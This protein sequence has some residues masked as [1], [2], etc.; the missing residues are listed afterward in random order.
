MAVASLVLGIVSLAF[1]WKAGCLAAGAAGLILGV[2]SRVRKGPGGLVLVGIILSSIG[3][4]Q[5]IVALGS[6]L[7]LH[8]WHRTPPAGIAV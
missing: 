4:A 1:P 7:F 2:V 3:L 6:G 5:S 8:H